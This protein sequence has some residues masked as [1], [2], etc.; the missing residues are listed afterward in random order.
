MR[1]NP[2]KDEK[3]GSDRERTAEENGEGCV[4]YRVF[5]RSLKENSGT[6]QLRSNKG[7]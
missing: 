3:V 7:F 4:I 6:G 2:N 1:K 5:D